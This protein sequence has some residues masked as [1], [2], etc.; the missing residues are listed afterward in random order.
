QKWSRSSGVFRL[1][2]IWMGVIVVVIGVVLWQHHDRNS[3]EWLLAGHQ[4]SR[5]ELIQIVAAFGKSGLND[6]EI[7]DQRILVPRKTRSDYINAM[8][9]NRAMPNG[10]YRPRDEVVR[11]GNFFE[12]AL[13]RAD[14]EKLALETQLGSSIQSMPGI[15]QA[16]VHIDES[17]SV[18]GLQR[19]RK[20]SGV[21][22]VVHTPGTE[23]KIERIES[24]RSLV[25][26]AKVELTAADVTVTDLVSGITYSGD[27]AS[28]PQSEYAVHKTRYER[29]W[30]EKIRSV[31]NIQGAE[32]STNVDVELKT[33]VGSTSQ[34]WMPVR[35]AAT[36][37]IPDSFYTQVRQQLKAT[38][39]RTATTIN[40]IE[41]ATHARVK[42]SVARLLPANEADAS[43]C[44]TVVTF[45]S[46][47]EQ[48]QETTSGSVLIPKSSLPA[49]LVCGLLIGILALYGLRREDYEPTVG[50]METLRYPE[51][52]DRE[53]VVAPSESAEV[54]RSASYQDELSRLVREN[55]AAA[56]ESL[57]QWIK[58]AG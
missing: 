25:A 2:A 51:E 39:S 4:F 11:N 10:T 24:I 42:K 31:L 20:A 12:T 34:T 16:F 17:V 40:E 29:N 19:Q 47:A 52:V 27:H 21:V 22:T 36:V 23:L 45:P 13:Q 50:A 1:L 18:R 33:P 58:K 7:Q 37:G 32:V 49:V 30:N 41:A 9:A 14:R 28:R 44:V 8:S 35:V 56:A 26:A 6:Y 3:R 53:A 5:T 55:P 15:E 54:D 46:L 38:G 57:K 43:S 48:K